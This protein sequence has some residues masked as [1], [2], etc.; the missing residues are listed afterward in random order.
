[1]VVAGLVYAQ[2]QDIPSPLVMAILPA[3]LLEA[4]LYAGPGFPAVREALLRWPKA[5]LAAAL[6]ISAVLPWLI[7]TLMSGVFAWQEFAALL[8]MVGTVAFWYVAL[9]PV[10]TVDFTLLIFLAVPF[11][12][13]TFRE[14]YP[15]A[16]P[17][18]RMD[19]LGKWM[20]IRLG[21]AVFLLVRQVEGIQFG[22]VP[23]RAEVLTGLK[24]YFRFLPF[25]VTLGYLLG[26]VQVGFP[27]SGWQ[28]IALTAGTFLGLFWTVSLGEEFF[29]RGLIQQW[30]EE[31]L[32][33][34]IAA[35]AIAS[36]LYGLVHLPF[37]GPFNWR[38]ALLVTLL[39]WFCG[40]A[41]Q[42]SRG[43][44]APMVTH[45]LAATT[46]IVAFQKGA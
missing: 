22:F 31:M 29:F 4:A 27:A 42:E 28:L 11:L 12:F 7:Y 9:P 24:Y 19:F 44:R 38:Y 21:F 41:F 37:R 25:G 39:G 13:K 40:Q 20:W 26:I 36:I 8:A 17:K 34:P 46:W 30:L 45:A 1:M 33:S 32:E 23:S 18:L 10:R 6:T 14:I 43:I 2:Q 15:D 16:M 5:Q 35:I 3:L